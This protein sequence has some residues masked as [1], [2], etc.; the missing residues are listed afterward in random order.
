MSLRVRILVVDADRD[1][2]SSLRTALTDLG[3]DVADVPGAGAAAPVVV[4]FAPEVVFARVEATG[5]G[6]AIAGALRA[7]G[8]DASLVAV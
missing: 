2:A 1:A 4:A 8:S 7:T 5:D 3:F 6:A